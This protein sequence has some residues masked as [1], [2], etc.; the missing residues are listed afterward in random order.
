MT[1]F[2]SDKTYKGIDFTVKRLPR[3]EYEQCIFD[4]CNFSDGYLDGQ[5]FMECTF[6]DCNLSNANI[7]NTTFKE[8]GFQ[9]SKMMGLRFE[10]CNSF[11]MDFTFLD[12][13]LNMSSFTGLE[14]K[15]QK[16][17]DCK[18]IGVD[19]T[20]SKLPQAVF[21]TCDLDKAIFSNTNLSKADFS[22]AFNFSIDSETNTL[23]N[24]TFS[25]QGLPNL[26]RKHKLNISP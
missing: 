19:F 18:L 14:L 8:V 17:T 21:D 5:N 12:C 10:T 4:T 25:T 2:I 11:L 1:D 20:D 26:L 7:A 6:T 9:H 23:L 24:A 13:H 3:A 16:F 22:T 15:N